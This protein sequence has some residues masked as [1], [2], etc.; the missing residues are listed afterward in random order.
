[1]KK[2][3]RV[4]GKYS[5]FRLL[6]HGRPSLRWQTPGIVGDWSKKIV[7]IRRSAGFSPAPTPS[8]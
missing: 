4:H 6:H 7:Q 1:M 5:V 2:T 8:K 3:L